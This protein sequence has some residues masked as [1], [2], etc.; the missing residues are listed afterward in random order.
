MNERRI[1][2]KRLLVWHLVLSVD[3]IDTAEVMTFLAEEISIYTYINI[4]DQYHLCFKTRDNPPLDMRLTK[5]EVS[6]ALKCATAPPTG[7]KR[8]EEVST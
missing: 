3:M 7:L 1:V 6:T 8:V 2:Q 4:I 5:N